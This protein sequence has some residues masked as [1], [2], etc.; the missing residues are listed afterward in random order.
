[1]K[2]KTKTIEIEDH[3]FYRWEVQ[4]MKFLKSLTILIFLSMMLSGCMQTVELGS[5]LYK[6]YWLE[7]IS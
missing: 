3:I 5:T 6:K 7:T 2:D 1:M 4:G